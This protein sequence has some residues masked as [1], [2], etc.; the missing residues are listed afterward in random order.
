MATHRPCGLQGGVGGRRRSKGGGGKQKQC[1]QGRG[2]TGVRM[3]T[4]RRRLCPGLCK[5][6]L[7]PN[8]GSGNGVWVE[9]VDPDPEELAGLKAFN[10]GMSRL[11]CFDNSE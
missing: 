10:G 1:H 4:G 9:T 5:R 6:Q 8:F 2:S 11:D 3:N 7:E